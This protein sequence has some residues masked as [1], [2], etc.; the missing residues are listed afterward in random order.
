MGRYNKLLSVFTLAVMM[1]GLTVV[2]SAQ[3]R[4][5]R[6]NT[7]YYGN[8]KYNR[9]LDSTIKNLRSNSKR[10]RDSL[11][12][13]LDQSRYDG[14]RR[15]DRLNDLAKKFR[16]A[17][18]KLDKDYKGYRSMRKTSDEARRVLSLG[19]QLGRALS[20]SKIDGAYSLRSTWRN[21]DRNLQTIS[22]AYNYNYNR[23]NGRYNRNDRSGRNG[24]YGRN[25]RNSRNDRYGRNDRNR[26][27]RNGRYG[28]GSN[29]NLR[30]TILRLQS[31][32]RQFE[33]RLDHLDKSRY[34][35]R[36]SRNLENLS[37]R[38]KKAVDKLENEYDGRR[39]YKDSYNEVRRVLSVGEQLDREISNARVS[40]SIRRDWNRIESDLRKLS[41]AYNLGY[42]G[43]NSRSSRVSDIWKKF[44]F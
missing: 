42:N 23:S 36:S 38:L 41:R 8:T 20:R 39:D 6:S 43:R 24:R 17:T 11:D 29:R 5:R 30:S 19:S 37:D 34:G 28:T 9:N 26:R 32:S 15:E 4:N 27:N 21:I 33:N 10:F 25:D 35:R 31:R 2:A 18:K 3:W 44:P 40:R 16:K 14:S 22:R 12:R 1:M 13:V 7:G